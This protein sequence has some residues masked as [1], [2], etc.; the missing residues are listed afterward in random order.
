M[1]IELFQKDI[2]Y[3]DPL[4]T[5]VSY[6]HEDFFKKV[7]LIHMNTTSFYTCYIPK[8]CICKFQREFPDPF[9]TITLYILPTDMAP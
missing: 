6:S 3:S 8:F 7:P 1:D 4:Y 2:D 5:C 9:L